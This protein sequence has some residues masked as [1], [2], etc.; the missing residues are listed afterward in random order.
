MQIFHQSRQPAEPVDADH[1]RGTARVSRTEAASQPHVPVF[2]VEF[3]PGARTNWHSHSGVQI[4]LIVEGRGRVQK[5]GEPMEE[6]SAGDTVSIAPDEKHWHGAAP[7]RFMT[8][9]AIL[10]VDDDGNPATWGDHVT[11]EEYG[12]APPID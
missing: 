3:E 8:H 1:F 4:L 11:D 6:V 9:I 10:E 7:T 12:A 5:W 2:R